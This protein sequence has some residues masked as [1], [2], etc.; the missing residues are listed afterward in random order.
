MEE[1]T[2]LM[3][4]RNISAKEAVESLERV[5]QKRYVALVPLMGRL[6]LMSAT[7]NGASFSK[8]QNAEDL[9]REDFYLL[10]YQLTK[11]VDAVLAD[12]GKL[13][14]SVM[15]QFKG[16]EHE[17]DLDT[18]LKL[19]AVYARWCAIS[20]DLY[21]YLDRFRKPRQELSRHFKKAADQYMIALRVNCQDGKAFSGLYIVAAT[22]GSGKLLLSAVYLMKSITAK[23]PFNEDADIFLSVAKRLATSPSDLRDV[24]IPARAFVACV[25][26]LVGIHVTGE[27]LGRADALLKAINLNIPNKDC[28][29]AVGGSSVVVSALPEVPWDA[30]LVVLLTATL[31]YLPKPQTASHLTE[32]LKLVIGRALTFKRPLTILACLDFVVAHPELS[33][34]VLPPITREVSHLFPLPDLSEALSKQG[35]CLDHLLKFDH[36]KL[37]AVELSPSPNE[38]AAARILLKCGVPLSGGSRERVLT[39]ESIPRSLGSKPIVIL[40]AANL[41]CRVGQVSKVADIDAVAAAHEYWSRKEHVVKIFVSEKHAQRTRSNRSQSRPRSRTGIEI[42]LDAVYDLFDDKT[43]VA[44]PP[45]NHDDSYMIEYALRVDG[46]ITSNDMFR[47]WISKHNLTGQAAKWVQSHVIAY[48]FVDSMYIPNPDFNMPSPCDTHSLLK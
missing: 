7:A 46:V 40:D 13:T 26:E 36:G 9:S 29:D 39:P 34:L 12:M 20:G 14:D 45:Q 23:F 37:P 19:E 4:I 28:P 2:K 5:W 17:L 21:R 15:S 31:D 8:D 16:R 22:G 47:D 41:A 25:L 24:P 10:F 35:L 33:S 38:T 48:T 1:E 32:S 30:L 43:V 11:G 44:I 27:S 18:T 42:N 6:K 3:A